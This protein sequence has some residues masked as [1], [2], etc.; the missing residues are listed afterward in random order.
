MIHW[1]V[2][3]FLYIH[4]FSVNS[5]RNNNTPCVAT[6][7][8]SET[9]RL[10]KALEANSR[11]SIAQRIVKLLAKHP[12]SLTVDINRECSVGNISDQV[13]KR[14]NPIIKPL[15]YAVGCEKPP[16]FP[17]NKFGEQSRMYQWSIYKLP[18]C[19]TEAAN[20]AK[21]KPAAN[22]L[23]FGGEDHE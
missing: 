4:F 15:G 20:D 1:D 3:F 17:M 12:K 23:P 22:D 5:M 6:L 19:E 13:G 18:D 7:S 9:K 10:I 16:T 14:I 8:S 21:P 2:S 11:S